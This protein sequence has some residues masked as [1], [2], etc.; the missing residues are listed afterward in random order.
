MLKDGGIGALIGLAIIPCFMIILCLFG[1]TCMGVA[2]GSYAAIRQ[3]EIGSV[4]AKSCFSVCQSIA[5]NS[6]T[7]KLIPVLGICGFIGG[8]IYHFI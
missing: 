5:T 8:I 1:F 4:P 6:L 3:A 2:A 7:Y